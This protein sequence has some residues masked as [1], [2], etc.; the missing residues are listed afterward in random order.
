MVESLAEARYLCT[1]RRHRG[2]VQIAHRTLFSVN[3]MGRRRK[4]KRLSDKREQTSEPR[5][6]DD[7][8][9]TAPGSAAGQRLRLWI[10]A[11]WSDLRFLFVFGLCLV[12]YFLS[13]LTPPVKEGFFPAYLRWNAQASG[14]ILRIFG[15]DVNVRDQ[16]LVSGQGPTIDIERGC[17]AVEPSALFVSAV[18]ASPVPLLSR[19]SAAVVGTFLLMVL[20]LVRVVTLFLCRV[21]FPKAFETM[22]LDVWQAV[23]VILAILLWAGWASRMAR[24]RAAQANGAT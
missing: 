12:L 8:A 2:G 15:Q 1:P 21:Y 23:F 13:T 6:A 5:G 17:D 22:H 7:L 3:D 20:N 16:S 24:R 14:A 18:L 4:S 11:N 10:R 19:L 9:A